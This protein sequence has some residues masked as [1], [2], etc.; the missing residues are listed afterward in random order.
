MAYFR[1]PLFDRLIDAEPQ[2]SFET[3]PFIYYNAEE[4]FLSIAQEVSRLL[5][6]R[7]TYAR[8]DNK[9][10]S[11]TIR[12]S[13]I[14]YGYIDFSGLSGDAP[15]VWKRLCDSMSETIMHFEPRIFHVHCLVDSYE[16]L[17]QHLTLRVHGDVTIE[18]H[19]QRI[20][21]PVVIQDIDLE[22]N[23]QYASP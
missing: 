17:T 8:L 3:K 14:G 21:F 11:Q 5:N 4:L 22:K 18:T 6:T 12:W 23:F 19:T 20:E 15:Y 10:V 16:R 13:I 9:D 7:S 1:A 2:A